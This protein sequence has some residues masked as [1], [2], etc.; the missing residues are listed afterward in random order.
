MQPEKPSRGADDLF[1]ER[2]ENIIEHALVRLSGL[3]DWASF[4]EAFGK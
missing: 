3:I 2:R 1:R 4:D